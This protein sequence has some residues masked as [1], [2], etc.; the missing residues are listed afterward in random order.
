MPTPTV[1]L[2]SFIASV[3]YGLPSTILY[4]LTF[5][6]ILNKRKSFDSSYFQI[7]VFDGFMNLFTYFN[8]FFTIR[9]SSITCYD[10]FMAPVFKNLANFRFLKFIATMGVHMAYVQYSISTLV[11][12]NRLSV[13]LNYSFFEPI[14]RKF[15]WLFIILI[16]F[17]PFLNTYIV[18]EYEVK[19]MY[20]EEDESFSLV[21]PGFP[22]AK[23]Y[24]I[25][26]P[27]MFI[28]TT[29]CVLLN[30][31]SILFLRSQSIQ[32][33]KAESNFLIILSITCLVQIIGTV[34][35]IAITLLSTSSVLGVLLM[36]LPY[37]SDGLC[38]V[39]PWLLVSFCGSIR[40]EIKSLFGLSPPKS[41]S[42]MFQVRSITN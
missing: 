17:L 29:L 36:I 10:C 35:T 37:S 34:L 40:K 28:T 31:F 1:P 15:T 5:Y 12:L 33:K 39:Q 4:F 2:I 27:F 13:L 24:S 6:V 38:L 21:S 32:K 19:V 42:Q 41:E 22:V 3:T 9:L 25:L 18:F 11:S 23:L 26:I 16:Y 8:A 20:F 30:S 7:Y 14:W